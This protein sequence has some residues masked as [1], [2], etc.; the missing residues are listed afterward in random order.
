EMRAVEPEAGISFE[1]RS[2]FPGLE[3]PPDVAVVELAKRL[4]GEKHHGK[5][6]YGTEAGL[7]SAAGIPTVVIGPGSIEQ[8]HKADEFIAVSELEKCGTF[9][10]RLIEHCRT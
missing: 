6:A 7:F 4:S 1:V 5:V 2:G 10:D 3:T 9:L 8:A